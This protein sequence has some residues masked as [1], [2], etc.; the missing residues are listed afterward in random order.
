[1][2]MQERAMCFLI[3]ACSYFESIHATTK[4]FYDNDI[5]DAANQWCTDESKAEQNYGDISTWDVSRV[6][7]MYSLFAH[8]NSETLNIDNWNTSNVR[9]MSYMFFYASEFNRNIGGK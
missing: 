8:C 6:T 5:G 7:D 2:K 9:T 3:T 1:M 4:I